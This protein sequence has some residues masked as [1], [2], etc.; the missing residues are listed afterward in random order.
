MGPEAAQ[1]IGPAPLEAPT[2]WTC[3]TEGPR[4]V[5][6]GPVTPGSTHLT[7]DQNGIYFRVSLL[8]IYCASPCAR[9]GAVRLL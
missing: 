3:V 4:L 7:H 2:S 1:A 5:S 9:H 6:P 8:S